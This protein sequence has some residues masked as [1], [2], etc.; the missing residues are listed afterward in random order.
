MTDEPTGPPRGGMDWLLGPIRH[1]VDVEIPKQHAGEHATLRVTIEARARVSP[2]R[3]WAV[4]LVLWGLAVLVL[5]ATCHAAPARETHERSAPWG[6]GAEGRDGW[7]TRFWG[8]RA[9]GSG[10]QDGRTAHCISW[11]LRGQRYYRCE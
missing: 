4:A 2:S 1:E 9:I 5:L 3:G 7:T 11:V 8:D 6:S 10:W